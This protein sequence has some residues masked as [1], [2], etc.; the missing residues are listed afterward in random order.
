MFKKKIKIIRISGSN[1]AVKDLDKQ[2]E[3]M[4]FKDYIVINFNMEVK[5]IG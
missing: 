5:E 2:L 1:K 3:E 4:G